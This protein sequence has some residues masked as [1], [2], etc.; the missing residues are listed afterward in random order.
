MKQKLTRAL[1]DEIRK[2]MPVLNEDEEKIFNNQKIHTKYPFIK[3][4]NYN[5]YETR[6]DLDI[7]V[8]FSKEENDHQRT[9]MG[10]TLHYTLNFLE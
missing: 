5:P 7:I 9:R 8:I 6:E 3:K 1:I 2:E 4:I 10:L